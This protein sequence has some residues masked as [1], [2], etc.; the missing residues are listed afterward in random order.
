MDDGFT[1]TMSGKRHAD[2]SSTSMHY[3]VLQWIEILVPQEW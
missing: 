3:L 1:A 2:F